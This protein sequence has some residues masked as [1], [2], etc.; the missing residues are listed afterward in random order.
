MT[1]KIDAVKV[2]GVVKETNSALNGKPFNHGEVVI[3]LAELIGRVVVDAAS[4]TVQLR[5]LVAIVHAH[6]AAT[7][8]VGVERHEQSS[9]LLS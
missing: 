6:I 7:I 3:G 8:K 5:E 4:N 1:Y 9:I 2:A